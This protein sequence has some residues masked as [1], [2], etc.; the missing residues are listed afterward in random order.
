MA[1]EK[2]K[3][4]T[5]SGKLDRLD[6]LIDRCCL[7]GRIQVE[8]AGEHI[9][10]SLG[11][12][13]LSEP[14]PYADRLSAVREVAH[15]L[16]QELHYRDTVRGSRDDAQVDNDLLSA[17]SKQVKDLQDRK[18]A[19]NAEIRQAEDALRDLSHFVDMDLPLKELYDS[20]FVRFRFGRMPRENAQKLALLKDDPYLLFFPCQTEGEDVWGVYFA[21]V[22]KVD[23]VDR[24]FASL[25]FQRLRLPQTY[26]TPEKAAEDCREKIRQGGEERQRLDDEL[27]RLWDEKGDTCD[28]M[29]SRL[30]YRSA[31]HEVRSRVVV[32]RDS[33]VLI[34]WVPVREE[35]A[36]RAALADL[37]VQA[38]LTR[39]SG[40]RGDAPPTKLKNG[41]LVRPYEEFVEMYGIPDYHDIDPTLFLSVIYTLLFGIMFAD[42]GQGLCVAALGL[43]LWLKSRSRMGGI[44]LRC[45]LSSA[46]FGTLFGS[47]FGNEHLLDGFY[48]DVL[49]IDKPIEIMR[50]ITFILVAAI[51]IGVFL[52]VVA[53][54]LG[55]ASSVK[56]GH[57]G[58]ALFSENGVAGIFTYLS[59]VLL[60]LRFMGGETFA[61]VPAGPVT[62]VL[63]VC[64]AVLYFKQILIGLVERRP[65]WK[66]DSIGDYLLANLFELIEYVLSYFSNTVSFLRVGA[67]VLVH[68]G[69]MLVVYS[70][71]PAA[72]AGRIAV[73]VLGNVLIMGIE[74]VLTYIQVLRLGFYEMFSRFYQGD[75]RP[76]SAFSLAKLAQRAGA[77][78]RSDKA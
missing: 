52:L 65:D 58:E 63:L 35:K 20:R 56:R 24:L 69:M 55:V 39:P 18:N 4:L 34:G 41:A 75:G 72:G 66:P 61:A 74:G 59:L 44:L 2:M 31:V 48:T 78:R 26:E 71:A 42:L 47:V 40:K 1:V 29:Y 7:D 60:I 54:L 27:R 51:G 14:D 76:F 45:G 67:F 16:G 38:E 53:M 62:A 49:H 15:D 70:M 23:E 30:L 46:V 13:P 9:S 36:V 64:L 68:A 25:Y 6:E 57:I 43:F 37:P 8:Q 28:E 19:L 50:D 22:N 17:L 73:L 3:L 10:G 21:P 33:F 5:V 77:A 11:Y 32:R 12:M